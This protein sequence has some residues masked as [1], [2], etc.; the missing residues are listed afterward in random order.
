MNYISEQ[1][2][3]NIKNCSVKNDV[4]NINFLNNNHNNS[5]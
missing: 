2:N 4:Y 1:N 3:Q 5:K